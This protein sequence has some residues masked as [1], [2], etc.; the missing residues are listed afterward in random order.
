M[1]ITQYTRDFED[2]STS[3]YAQVTCDNEVCARYMSYAGS[4][5]EEA[6]EGLNEILE[7]SPTDDS[8]LGRISWLTQKDMHF[9]NRHCK[10]LSR[11]DFELIKAE[12]PLGYTWK[13][14]L[15]DLSYWYEN[16]DADPSLLLTEFVY[17]EEQIAYRNKKTWNKFVVDSF[18][19][20]HNNPDELMFLQI[21]SKQFKKGKGKK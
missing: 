6:L 7:I 1:T 11:I 14:F 8:S 21:I 10:A 16:P 19:L 9:C 20:L 18:K 13:G 5:A 12:I 2:G 17:L 4:T 15:E 3:H